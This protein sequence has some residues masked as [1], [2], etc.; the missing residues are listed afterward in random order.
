MN[1]IYYEDCL[2]VLPFIPDKSIDLCFTDPPWGHSY[3]G[4]R[5]MGIN[6]K[7]E[8]TERVN[9][10]DD[11]DVEFNLAWF[12]EIKRICKRIV[13]AMGWKHFNWWVENTHPVGYFIWHFKNGQ[14]STKISQFNSVHPL[15]CYGDW[16]DKKF[17]YNCR[18]TYIRNGFLNDAKEHK[19]KHPSPK[20]FEDWVLLIKELEPESLIDPFLGSGTLAEV[21]E[22]LQV[23]YVGI[24][25]KKEY[26]DDIDFRIKRGRKR[27]NFLISSFLEV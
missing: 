18:E 26:K 2:K 25:V 20:P 17:R 7:T 10:S 8:H 11:F 3:N 12:H 24:E 22:F 4:Q 23:P 15:L 27:R 21:G 1:E 13:I 16:K 9:Y 5:P 14:G 6:T 19:F